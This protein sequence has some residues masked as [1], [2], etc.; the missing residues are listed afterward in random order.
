MIMVKTLFALVL[1]VYLTQNHFPAGLCNQVAGQKLPTQEPRAGRGRNA[2]RYKELQKDLREIK[3]QLEGVTE[4]TKDA[5]FGILTTISHVIMPI[6]LGMNFTMMLYLSSINMIPRGEA[7]Q[8]DDEYEANNVLHRRREAPN[9]PPSYEEATG[10]DSEFTN[11][12]VDE[13]QEQ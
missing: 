2:V 3:Q 4:F 9:G 6:M 1:C 10:G 7:I 8:I 13:D 12:T 5:R 11:G